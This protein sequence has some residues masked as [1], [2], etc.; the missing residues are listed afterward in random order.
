MSK[1]HIL[2]AEDDLHIRNGLVALLQAEG[3]ETSVAKDGEEA[4]K[5]AC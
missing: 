3:Y 2:I 1:K 4:V 5:R